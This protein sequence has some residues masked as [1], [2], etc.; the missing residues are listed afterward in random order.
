MANIHSQKKRI[1]RAERERLEN[2]RYTSKIKTYFRRL[3]RAVAAGEDSVAEQ[4]HRA[5]VQTIDKAVK[6][7][8]LHRNTGA[9]KKSRA[10]RLQARL[11]PPPRTARHNESVHPFAIAFGGQHFSE[12]T[13]PLLASVAYLALYGRRLQTLSR[14]GRPVEHWRIASFVTGVVLLTAVQVG[15]LDSIADQVLVAHMAQHI[16]IGDFCSLLIVFGLTGPVL[17]PL[18]H[19][20]AT[21]PLRVLAHPLIALAM[22]ALDLYA[23][24][25]PLFYQLAIRHDLVHALEHAC[26]FWFGALL[27]LGLIGPL[28][29]PR[30]FAGW[31]TL[32]YI[33]LVRFTGA[34]LGNV[35]IW[36]QTIFYP[37]Y[38]ATDAAKGLNALSDQNLAGGLMMIEEMIL[39]TILLGWLFYRFAQQDEERQALMDFAQEHG[40]E[41]SEDRARRAAFAGTTARLRE[42]L[43]GEQRAPSPTIRDEPTSS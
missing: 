19:I 7:G 28:P 36:A 24:H 5:L 40:V 31:G 23:W 30:W 9:R 34:V 37:V 4:E 39:T 14:E 2:R 18:L 6:R 3:E 43:E 16:V 33:I 1:L 20:R 17:Q 27:W 38:K 26:F 13:P 21:R 8:A 42:R 41:L 35:L 15:P 32:G 25:L 10:A 22:W 12:L 11:A 29:K